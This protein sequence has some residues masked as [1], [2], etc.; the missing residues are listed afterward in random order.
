MQ[1]NREKLENGSQ[2]FNSYFDYKFS[3]PLS[4][5]DVY[6]SQNRPENLKKIVMCV[7]NFNRRLPQACTVTPSMCL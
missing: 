1:F 6:Y 5:L 7:L 2:F 4:K 3:L